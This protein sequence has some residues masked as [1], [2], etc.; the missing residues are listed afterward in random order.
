MRAQCLPRGLYVAGPQEGGVTLHTRGAI[1]VERK[2]TLVGPPE[3]RSLPV[4]PVPVASRRFVET[5]ALVWPPSVDSRLEDAA[6]GGPVAASGKLARARR[7]TCILDRSGQTS[8]FSFDDDVQ[9]DPE[10]RGV[11]LADRALRVGEIRGMPRELRV[12]RVPA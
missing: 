12:P 5:V 1:A 7:G 2:R 6:V 9:Y 3:L 11:E 8:A 10:M 4:D